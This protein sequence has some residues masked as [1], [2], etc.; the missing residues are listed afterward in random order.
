MYFPFTFFLFLMVP[1][2]VIIDAVFREA[3][4][5]FISPAALEARRTSP[6]ASPEEM[7]R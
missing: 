1:F 6:E 7:L 3:N 4:I 5:I 2:V